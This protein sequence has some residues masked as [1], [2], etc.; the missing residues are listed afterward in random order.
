VGHPKG[1]LGKHHS[2]ESKRLMSL[3]RS[4]ENNGRWKGG[5]TIINRGIRWSA[6]YV[7]WKKE[8]LKRDNYTCR[9]CGSTKSIDVHHTIPFSQ[10]K[11][12]IF[13]IN[14]GLSLCENCHRRHT[15]WQRLNKGMKNATKLYRMAS[16][17]MV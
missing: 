5:I 9:D 12:L 4:G 14:N 13:D 2:E 17:Q 16:V 3:H 10:N 7:R 8:V 11:E 1:M 6:E 15:F